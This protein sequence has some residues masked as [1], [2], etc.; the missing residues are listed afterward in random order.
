MPRRAIKLATAVAAVAMPLLPQAATARELRPA[1]VRSQIKAVRA[2]LDRIAGRLSVAESRLEITGAA[3]ARHRRALAKATVARTRIRGVLSAQASE[4]YR[5]GEPA[6]GIE[7]LFSTKD[8]SV[9]LQR[10]AFLEQ[11]RSGERGL[12]EDLRALQRS[13]AEDSRRLR[14][15]LAT[16]RSAYRD[17][18]AQRRAL[19]ARLREYEMLMRFLDLAGGRTVL[20][21]SRRGSRGFVCPVA[22]PAGLYNDYGA[23]RRGG[24]HTGVDM[25]ASSGTRVVAV[26]P[27]RVVDLPTGGWIGRGIIIRDLVGNEWWYAHLSARGVRVGERVVPGEVI[28]RVGCTGNCYGPHL[29][30][31]WHPGGGGPRNP[32]RILRAAC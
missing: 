13:A 9:A 12:Q 4:L 28:G 8:P 22:G 26:L 16:S 6:A 24:P 31:E 17:L 3:L 10:I 30:F 7:V 14:A 2:D 5:L 15:A 18:R 23:P 25:P 11:I 21:A 29:H 32:Y 20:R 1:Q 27:A 19:S